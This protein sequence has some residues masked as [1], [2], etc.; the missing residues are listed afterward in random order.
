MPE[1]EE[2]ESMVVKKEYV[3]KRVWLET[4]F[5]LLSSCRV[6][7]DDDDAKDVDM[8]VEKRGEL[9]DRML[10]SLIWPRMPS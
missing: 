2:L 5:Q 9:D 7:D 4:L 1:Q 8:D 10:R 3:F 6:D